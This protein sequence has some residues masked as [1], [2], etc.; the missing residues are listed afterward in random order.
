MSP[1]TLFLLGLVLSLASLLAWSIRTLPRDGWQFV[2]ASPSRQRED[3]SWEGTNY[4]FYGVYVAGSSALAAALFLLLNGTAG[5][6][7][8]PT[9][10]TVALVLAVAAP[11]ARW[12]ARLVEGKRHT[13][14]IGGA[15]FVGLLILPGVVWL[16]N[17]LIPAD[18]ARLALLPICAAMGVSYALGEG[19]GRL[20]CISF[21]CCF[22]RPLHELSPFARRLLS[23]VAIVYRDPIRKACYEGKLAG[24]PLVP[25][26]AITA[27][28]Y[29]AAASVG[30]ALFL[31]GWWKTAF[32]GSLVFTQVWRVL[33][34]TL[35]ADFRGGLKISPYQ[36][37][38]LLG[39]LYATAVA[40]LA[41]PA[42]GA[43]CDVR[44]GLALFRH[45]GILLFLQGLWLGLFLY[46]GRSTVTGSSL[47]FHVR[48][49]RV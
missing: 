37:M 8:L 6:A 44:L 23:P 40:F 2:G 18:A 48:R 33:S 28:L 16:V 30:T 31:A 5:N 13:F 14:T 47:T 26:Q 10:A 3:G 49:D 4:T 22:G 29:T 27:C 35:R 42:A 39:I 45:S 20:A 41:D 34:E 12:I 1:N 25:I 9:A 32:L 46:M 36:I 15:S 19:L 38:A 17:R 21:G 24:V 7:V 43:A 11:A